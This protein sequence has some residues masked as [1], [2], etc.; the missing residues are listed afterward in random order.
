MSTLQ[1]AETESSPFALSPSQVQQFHE[2]GYLGPF[3]AF[4]I[5]EMA[6]L[7]AAIEDV[8]EI[9]PPDHQRRDHNRHLDDP[10]VY[11]VSTA[12][13]IVDK[14]VSILGPDLLLWRAHMFVKRPGDL[15]IPW[16][17][18]ANY[19][20]LEPAVVASAWL[21]IDPATT[22]NSCV[23]L[24]PG[25]HRKIVPHIAVPEGVEA[26]W[27][28]YADPSYFDTADAIDMELEPGEFFLFNERTL[29]FSDTNHS[30]T[31]RIGLSL[32]VIP[33][34]TRVLDWDSPDHRTV[35]I[36]GE[37]RM[38]FNPSIRSPFATDLE[39]ATR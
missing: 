33:P 6:E 3:R 17:Q 35:V 12:P 5:D 32:R 13:A 19:W 31:R 21:A 39:N 15:S 2:Q 36:S 26:A 22:E 9:D 4:S 34:I 14:F 8:L 7:R 1:I 20:P 18:D 11:Q 27:P 16:H 24:I 29:H 30:D 28:V 10:T 37:D 25:T 38:Q 23:R